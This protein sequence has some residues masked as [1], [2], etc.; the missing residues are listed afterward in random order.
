MKKR[1]SIAFFFALTS[2]LFVELVAQNKLNL[3]EIYQLSIGPTAERIKIDGSLDEEVWK[4]SAVAT[5]FWVSFPMDGIRA[6]PELKTLVRLTYDDE[7]IYVAAECIGPGPYIIQ[8]LKRDNPLFWRG[9][10]FGLVFDPVNERSNGFV[11][12]VNP[13]AVQ[14]ESLITGQTGRRGNSGS[15]SGINGA[16]DNKWYSEVQILED[17]W[18]V[19]IAI[20]FKSLRFGDK[21]EWGVNFVRGD[22]KNNSYHTWSP[23]PVQF[24]GVDLGYTG[25]LIWDKAP[26]KTKKNISAIPY[27]LGLGKKNFETNALFDQVQRVGLDAKVA[28]T[29][30][31]NLDLTINP[32]FS[33]VDVDEQQTNLTTVNLRFPERRLFFLENSDVF[34]DFGIPPMRPF[35]SRKIG[36]D[37]EGNTIPILYG[38]RLSGNLNKNLRMSLMNSQTKSEELPGNNYTSLAVRQRVFAAV[39]HQGLF[40]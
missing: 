12:A 15:V 25:K 34:S 17:R 5:D 36:L 28:V 19:E 20:P 40:S 10:A 37:E 31:L 4:T 1:G 24:R 13:E 6:S 14:S 38:A 18:T 8:S 26:G 21:L 3:Q 9:D 7:F 27:L 22:A 32:D 16:W 30:S 23:V 33:Q 2:I 11:F 39:Y 29:S 35:F